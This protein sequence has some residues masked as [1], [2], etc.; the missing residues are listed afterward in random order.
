MPWGRLLAGCGVRIRQSG[1]RVAV[2][3]QACGCDLPADA[4][5]CLQ[6]GAPQEAICTSCS[7]PLVPDARFCAFCGTATGVGGSFAVVAQPPAGTAPAAVAPAAERRLCSVLFAD[8]VGFTPL[9]EARDPE[10]VREL[11]SRYFDVAR[12]VVARHGGAVEKFIGDAVMAVWGTPVA[13]E[14]DAER[15]VRAGLQLIDAVT[16]L[17]AE[18]GVDQ[19]TARAG[20]VTGEVAVTLGAVGEGMVAGDAVNTAARVQ[21]AA[22][23]GTVLVDATTRRLTASAVEFSDAGER[24]LKG[25][26]DAEH[27]WQATRVVA[28]V[29]GMQRVDGLEAGLVGRDAELRLVKELFHAAADRGQPRLVLVAGVAGVGKSR[30]GWEFEKYVDGLAQPIA[31]HRGRCL[32]YGEGVAFWALAEAVRQRL[33]IA[34]DDP[35]SVAAEMMADGLAGIVADPAER[36][37]VAARLARLLGVPTLAGAGDPLGREELFAGWRLFFERLAADRPV[38]LLIED[39]Q[40]ADTGLLDFLDHLI[41]WARDLPIFVLVLARPELEQRRAG[42]GVGRNRTALT[43]DPLDAASM[44]ALV[45]SLVPGIPTSAREAITRHAQGIPL[46]A[47]ETVRSLVDRDIV[48]PIDGVYRLVGEVGELSV[49]D[50]LHALLAARLD[51]L[52]PGVRAIAADAAVLGASFPAEAVVAVCGQPEPA[53]RAGLA[54][55][56]RREVLEISADPLSPQRGEYRFAQNLLRQVAYDTLSRRDRKSRHLAVAAHLRAAFPDDGEEVAD[57]IA[58]HYRD[59]LEAVPDDSDAAQLR[60]EATGM[61]VRA[62]ERARRAGAPAAAAAAYATAAELAQRGDDADTSTAA[63]WWEQAAQNAS[64]AA[65][66]PASVT[67]AER[68]HA[69]HSAAGRT[70]DAARAQVLIGRS[71]QV[72]GQISAARERLTAALEVLRVDPDADTVSALERLAK[73]EAFASDAIAEGDRLSAEALDLGQ[74]LDLGDARLAR[75]LTTRGMVHAFCNRT[76]EAAAA[77]KHAADLAGRSGDRMEQGTAL[78]SLA[79]TLSSSDPAAAAAAARAGAEMLRAVGARE[80][81]AVALSNLCEALLSAGEWDEAARELDAAIERDGLADQAFVQVQRG[82]LAALRGDHAKATVVLDG[83]SRF[84]ATEDVQVRTALL[85]LQ[86]AIALAAGDPAGTLDR[87]HAVVRYEEGLGVRAEAVRWAWPLAARAAHVLG[88]LAAER[89]LLAVLDAHP[90]GHLPLLLRAEADLARGRLTV[91]PDEAGALFERGI[92]VL[93]RVP[94][95]FHLGDGLLDYA[96]LMLITGDHASAEAAVTEATNIAERLRAAPLRERARDTRH[97]LARD[98]A[99]QL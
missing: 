94:F 52:E 68:A 73:V 57:A 9:S 82:F 25:K 59:A 11:L 14:E 95:P 70:R 16:V 61:W 65:D 50:S 45:E 27:L 17:G 39:A 93:R 99:P 15:A 8:L 20:V 90:I 89:E 76:V 38:V 55:L 87:A 54:E 71:L 67:Y 47:V 44:V 49:P 77:F 74:A 96:D 56:L 53:V 91:D 43:L 84:H 32:S 41:D 3:C 6:C 86:A 28:A 22:E 13:T 48:Q 5:F 12:T 78:L 46:F 37:Y 97:R 72:A 62:A 42:F 40:Y 30:L 34:E 31:W 7:T 21:A 69:L 58:R 64:V 1:Y 51:A 98:H 75:L 60:H 19:L 24:L 4:R 88:D 36:E 80:P 66:D 10:E 81:L 29:G 63:L 2:A 35:T 85:L 92:A 18:A 23:P 33:S 83:L 26:A 79:D